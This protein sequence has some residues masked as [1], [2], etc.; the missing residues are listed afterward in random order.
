MAVVSTGFFDGVHT[1][2]RRVI[3]TL[4]RTAERLGDESLVLTF[5]PHP[6]IMLQ[7]DAAELRLLS[8]LEEKIAMLKALG[9]DRVEVIP[10]T[11]EFAS[12]DGRAYLRDI[13]RDGFGAKALVL[14]YDNRIGSDMLS[15]ELVKVLASELGMEMRIV[16]KEGDASSTRIRAALSACDVEN[17]NR[18]LGYSYPLSGTI[19]SGKRLG[20]TIGFPTANMLLNDPLK[21]IPGRGVYFTRVTVMGRTYPGMT[22]VGDIIET[23][24]LGFNEDIY[25]MDL[26]LEFISYL[27]G[28]KTFKGLPE[29]KEQLQLDKEKILLSLHL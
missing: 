11:R 13:V 6:R 29:L 2:H 8:S 21:Q 28:M 1:G 27:R 16:P 10:F 4:V 9:V 19:V 3:E 23:H 24:I 5:W 26:S 18:M 20:R 14:G 22:N 7:K 15:P 25:G 12:M 17:A